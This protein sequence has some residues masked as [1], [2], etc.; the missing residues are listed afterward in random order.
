MSLEYLCIKNKKLPS[1]VYFLRRIAYLYIPN[2]Y[3]CIQEVK[4]LYEKI[5]SVHIV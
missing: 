1:V 2:L 4:E 3:A 5:F